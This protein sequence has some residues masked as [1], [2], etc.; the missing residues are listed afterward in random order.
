MARKLYIFGDGNFADMAHYLFSTDS[1]YEVAGF[2][3]D[4]P[5]LKRD[6]FNGLPV[7]AYEEF[8]RTTDRDEVD[9]YVAIGVS[10][11]NRVRAQ[12]TAQVAADGYRLASF[13]SSH[14]RVPPGLVVHPNTMIMDQVNIHPKVRIGAD[15]VIWS[16]SRIA[17]NAQI[18][19]H[20]WI[21]SAVVGDGAVVGD[22]TFVGLNATIAP[23][24]R[25]GRHNLI[26]AAAVI[27]QDT[28][29]HQVYRG[30]RSV[31]SKVS[32]L[33]IGA[34]RLIR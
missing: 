10:G 29:D 19:D 16:N 6:S 3:I 27:L 22:Y 18:G 7:I 32:T 15:T 33:R 17:L 14:A 9:I 4:A 12:K 11:I 1:G 20:V 13:V 8:L 23:F 26:G 30:P 31:A 2:T 28:Q 5:F 34:N 21:T 24:L 25:V